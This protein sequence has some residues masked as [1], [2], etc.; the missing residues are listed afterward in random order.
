M[1]TNPSKMATGN[2]VISVPEIRTSD[3]GVME[4]NFLRKDYRA[5]IELHGGRELPLLAPVIEIAGEPVPIQ[6]AQWTQEGYW[7]PTFRVNHRGVDVTGRIFAPQNHRGF[8]YVLA[9]NTDSPAHMRA[10]WHGEWGRTYHVTNLSKR[11]GGI[12]YG[13]INLRHEETP[14]MEYRGATPIFAV[15]LRSSEKMD[16]ELSASQEPVQT[17]RAHG[18]GEASAAPGEDLC[19]KLML[20]IQLKPGETRTIALYVGFGLEEISAVASAVNLSRYGWSTLLE[21]LKDWLAERTITLDGSEFDGTLNLNSFYN[22][23]YSQGVTLDTEDLVLTTSRSSKYHSSATYRDRDAMLWS[24]PAVL[25]IDAP[26][27]RKMIEYAFTT[28]LK[29][30][31]MHSRFIDGIVLEPGFELDELC[32]PIR[33][34]WM[35]VRATGDMSVLFDRRIQAGV[36]HFQQALAARRHPKVPLFE[37]MLLPSDDPASY[38]YVTYDNVRVWRALNDVAWMYDRIR[39]LDRAQEAADLAEDVKKAIMRHCIVTGPDGP[40]FAWAVDLEGRYRLYDEPHG[41]LQLLSYLDF[42]QSDDVVYQNTVRWIHSDEN[43]NSFSGS[44]FESPGSDHE[45]HPSIL[46]VANDLLTGR[47]EQALAFLRRTGLDDGIA[48]ECIDEN[49]GEAVSGRGFA[50]GAGL[51]AFALHY[52]L[53]GSSEAAILAKPEPRPADRLY[54]PPPP[55]IK[56]ALDRRLS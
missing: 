54:Q 47:V 48:S 7:L 17:I 38:Q 20:D 35:Y 34:L 10:G 37:T 46:S 36:N 4:V 33:A 52:A 1:A 24:L 44:I 49:T 56:N 53:R 39:D 27:A 5:V 2:L 18:D 50:S 22:Y 23:F 3:G 26:Q 16:V 11:M 32:A 25:Q 19:H 40:V 51:L 14:Y 8:V 21:C 55:E 28:Q 42:V 6:A 9:F 13:G 31:G 29:N 43:P 12:R 15:A 41:S 30:L 45:H